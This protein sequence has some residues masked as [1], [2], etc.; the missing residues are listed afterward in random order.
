MCVSCLGLLAMSP[1]QVLANIHDTPVFGDGNCYSWLENEIENIVLLAYKQPVLSYLE[2][3][4][5]HNTRIFPKLDSDSENL[6]KHLKQGIQVFLTGCYFKG[7]CM[8]HKP[9]K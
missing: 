5:C 6:F 8:A 1:R 7:L 2:D 4:Y 3:L 9:S